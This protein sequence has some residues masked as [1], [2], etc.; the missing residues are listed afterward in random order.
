MAKKKLDAKT[1]LVEQFALA[2]THKQWFADLRSS[3]KGLTVKEALWKP[4]K[5]DHNVWEIVSHLYYWNHRFLTFFKEKHPGEW[6]GN[7]D[8]TFLITG[9]RTPQGLKADLKKLDALTKEFDKQIR[10]CKP[11][12]LNR[13]LSKSFTSPW[14]SIL[15]N[16]S[17]HTAYHTGQIVILRKMHK[18]WNKKNGV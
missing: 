2:H 7:N 15:N 3:V 4:H 6:I 11:A 18:S 8:D 17:A 12:K 14:Y 5:D 1:I 10:K 9:K 16:L 13:P